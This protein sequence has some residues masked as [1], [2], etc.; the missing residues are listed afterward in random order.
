M[1]TTCKGT[2]IRSTCETFYHYYHFPASFPNE[3]N[4]KVNTLKNKS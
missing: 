4:P 2:K 3:K 1:F